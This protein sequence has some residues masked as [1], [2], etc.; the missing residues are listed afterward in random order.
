MQGNYDISKGKMLE[1]RTLLTYEGSC[2]KI[3]AEYRDLR[4]GATPQQDFR[5]G[6]NLKNLG[7]FLD[8]NG[9]F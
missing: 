4:I 2:Y 1:T 9:S 3:L 6:L 7:S 5:I 8:F